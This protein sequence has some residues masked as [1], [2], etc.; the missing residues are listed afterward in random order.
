[1]TFLVQET[2]AEYL[3]D[4]RDKIVL[5]ITD[6]ESLAAAARLFRSTRISIFCFIRN[7]ARLKHDISVATC[8]HYQM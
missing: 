8:H 2:G 4:F 6:D 7:L 3:S 5:M 1:M